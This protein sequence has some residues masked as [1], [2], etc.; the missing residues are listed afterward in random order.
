M[1]ADRQRQIDRAWKYRNRYTPQELADNLGVSKPT[2]ISW[3]R[4]GWLRAARPGPRT[5][6]I[7]A[8]AVTRMLLTV[9]EVAQLVGK[10]TAMGKAKW[11]RIIQRDTKPA[12]MECA[13]DMGSERAGDESRS[14]TPLASPPA[15]SQPAPPRESP[16]ASQRSL[17]GSDEG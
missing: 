10:R 7:R 2:V 6:R 8:N 14:P 16:T 17:D 4:R 3:I 9:P 5:W 13:R 1:R 12:N 11:T 15:K